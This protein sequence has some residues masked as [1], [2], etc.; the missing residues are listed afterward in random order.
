M[1]RKKREATRSFNAH[2]ASA[3][4]EFCEDLSDLCEASV[5]VKFK[6]LQWTEISAAADASHMTE[7]FPVFLA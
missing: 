6:V 4:S 7:T 1:Q 2:Q 3:T 5:K